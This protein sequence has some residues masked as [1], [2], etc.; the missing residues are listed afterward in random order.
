MCGRGRGHRP[1]ARSVQGRRNSRR[2]LPVRERA[3]QE[4]SVLQRSPQA[5][6]VRWPDGRAVAR[7]AGVTPG[8]HHRIVPLSR[9]CGQRWMQNSC[10]T[11][12][13]R[14]MLQVSSDLGH[15]FSSSNAS[16]F[17]LRTL[18]SVCGCSVALELDW[19]KEHVTNFRFLTL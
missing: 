8:F 15:L 4:R 11:L 2:V 10:L 1:A 19:R 9:L 12:G 16:A 7:S 3:C 5:H 14:R 18:H 17:F 6:R 13:R